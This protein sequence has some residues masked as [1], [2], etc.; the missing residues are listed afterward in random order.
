MKPIHTI[1]VDLPFD[2]GLAW[3]R[4]IRNDMHLDLIRKLKTEFKQFDSKGYKIKTKTENHNIV[5]YS[6]EF[7]DAATLSA[8]LIMKE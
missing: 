6:I 7:Y 2:P 4:H 8:Y 3:L 1:S 5:G